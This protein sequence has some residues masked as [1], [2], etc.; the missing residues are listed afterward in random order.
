MTF[1]LFITGF[2]AVA[3]F[4]MLCIWMNARRA[5]RELP[6]PG[7]QPGQRFAPDHVAGAGS[8]A[9]SSPREAAMAEDNVVPFPRPSMGGRDRYYVRS[10]PTP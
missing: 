7:A 4:L 5:G 3:T 10:V 1:L 2:Y 8:E 6:T 9:P